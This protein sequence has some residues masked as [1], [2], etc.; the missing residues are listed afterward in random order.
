MTQSRGPRS[1]RVLAYPF[2]LAGPAKICRFP[3]MW[4]RT[5]PN[6]SSPVIAITVL[7]PI[8]VAK[9]LRK[10][11]MRVSDGGAGGVSPGF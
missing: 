4:A 6:R 8:E 7:L 1:W 9:G 2:S 10:R 3:T 5:N 11:G